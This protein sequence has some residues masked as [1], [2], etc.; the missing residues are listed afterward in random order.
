[1]T[2]FIEPQNLFALSLNSPAS[3]ALDG[4]CGGGPEGQQLLMNWHV[5][6]DP[7]REH[8]Y[9]Q[10]GEGREVKG[11]ARRRRRTSD[12]EMDSSPVLKTYRKLSSKHSSLL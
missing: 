2:D 6:M 10:Y 8:F 9:I 5:K 4:A 7:E 11:A 12:F 3:R 1:M